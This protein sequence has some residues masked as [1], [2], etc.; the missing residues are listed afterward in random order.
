MSL[1]DKDKLTYQ[2]INSGAEFIYRH[3]IEQHPEIDPVHYAGGCY[4]RECENTVETTG[5]FGPG[6]FCRLWGRDFMRVHPADF[7]KFGNR[8][9]GDGK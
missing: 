6:I 2:Q 3:E 7:C 4:C 5:Y 1:I 9:A 8:R